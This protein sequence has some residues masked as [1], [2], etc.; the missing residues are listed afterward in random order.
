MQW[1]SRHA[2]T[3]G[4][5]YNYENSTNLGKCNHQYTRKMGCTVK[6]MEAEEKRT[7]CEPVHCGRVAPY[8]W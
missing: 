4:V 8:W 2:L 1:L 5:C 6:E 7:K 3:K